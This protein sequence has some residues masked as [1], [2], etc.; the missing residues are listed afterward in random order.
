MGGGSWFNLYQGDYFQWQVTYAQG[1][2]RYVNHTQGFSPVQFNGSNFG[3][4]LLSDGVFSVA[5]GD[6]QLTTVWG[7]NAAYDH[8][9]LSNF[10][11]SIYGAW[12]RYEYGDS[13]NLAICTAQTAFAVGAVTFTPAQVAAGACNNNFSWWQLGSRTQYNFTPWF[14]VGFD[15]IYSKIQSASNGTVAFFTPPAGV[16]KPATFYAIQDQDNYAFRIRVHRDIVP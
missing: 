7:V 4:G 15:V 12:T 6:V 14:Y 2:T 10:R 9:W 3:Y 1:A 11:T 8:F 5:T 16:A 13:A